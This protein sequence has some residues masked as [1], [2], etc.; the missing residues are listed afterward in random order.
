MN[1]DI[2][3]IIDLQRKVC[4]GIYEK[5]RLLQNVND[6]ISDYRQAGKPVLF[7][8]HHEVG[9]EKGSEGWQIV[10]ELDVLETR[11]FCG[12]NSCQ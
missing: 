9:L 8:Q 10:P 12:Q 11:L 2:L 7:V 5:E 6:R 4:Q 1:K 3:I